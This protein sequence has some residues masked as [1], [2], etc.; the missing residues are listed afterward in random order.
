MAARHALFVYVLCY[1]DRPCAYPLLGATVRDLGSPRGV[2][3]QY[4]ALAEALRRDGPFDVVHGYLA[5]PS[6]LVA[7]L[8]ARRLGVPSVVTMD[9]G[10]F[11]A[12][13]QI[14]YGLQLRARHRLAV[15]ATVRLA[16]RITVCSDHQ[17]RL[18]RIHGVE[19]V[20]IPLG[21]DA[22]RFDLRGAGHGSGDRPASEKDARWRVIHV[23][24]LNRVKDQTTLLEAFARIDRAHLDIVGEDT[25]GGSVQDLARQ[26]G[27][28]AR[29]T[30]HGFQPTD[31]IARLYRRADLFVLSSRHEAANVAVLEAAASG[32]ATVGTHVGYLADWSPDR[33]VTVPVGDATALARAI[34]D[35]LE[36]PDRRRRIAAAAREWT[37]AH[38]ADWS[39][40]AF[41]RLYRE[42]SAGA[43][44]RAN[45]PLAR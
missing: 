38:D 24:S 36:D 26:R 7:S 14:G 16:H 40:A 41:E 3:R 4:G 12:L 11:V 2:G 19:P 13:P 9:S 20:V 30:F 34:K 28:A 15:A 5:L 8:S 1:P 17:A 44:E 29:V 10:E 45:A 31:V 33:A 22:G 6:G 27:L 42:L 37:L 43:L 39:A 21:V 23:A 35:L 18:A 32:L 25:L